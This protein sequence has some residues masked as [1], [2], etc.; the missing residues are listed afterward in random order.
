MHALTNQSD[1]FDGYYAAFSNYCFETLGWRYNS[2]VRFQKTEQFAHS[3]VIYDDI[4]EA[5]SIV[6]YPL[7]YNVDNLYDTLNIFD[8]NSGYLRNNIID[9]DFYEGFTSKQ[10]FI[11]E[12]VSTPI[13]TSPFD[14][15][16]VMIATKN[17][18]L[19][20]NNEIH[21]Y[22]PLSSSV[23]IMGISNIL[24]IDTIVNTYES[25]H[26]ETNLNIKVDA[27]TT[28]SIDETDPRI[29]HGVMYEL[30]SGD[31]YIKA[32]SE[33]KIPQ[34]N[35]FI[36]L[37][38]TV[39]VEYSNTPQ[40][41]VTCL[42]AGTDV[43]YKVCDRQ[44]YQEYKYDSSKP[45][46]ST[47]NFHKDPEHINDS[48]LIYPVVPS[49]NCN[50]KSNGT[51]YDF[52]E[53]LNV[54]ML[55]FDY[56]PIGNFSENVYTASDF[57]S[58][59]YVTNKIDNILYVNDEVT[60]YKDCILNK[61]VQNP[62]RKLLID[63]VNIKTASAY[64][65]ANIQSLEF[66][67]SGVK[68]SIKLNSKV[69]NSYIHLDEYTGFEVFVINDY[70]LTKKNELY[71]SIEEKFILLVNHQFY[72]EYAREAENNIKVIDQGN[73][74]PHAPY[75]AFAAPYSLDFASSGYMNKTF[76]GYKKDY[77]E[78][79]HKSLMSVIDEHNLWSSLFV[80]YDIPTD[81]YT[82]D[83]TNQ[84]VQTYIEPLTEYNDYVTI[85]NTDDYSLGLLSTDSIINPTS[86]VNFDL[87]SSRSESFVVTKA[88]GEYNHQ[89]QVLLQSIN[90]GIN[91]INEKYANGV[92]AFSMV[93]P[94]NGN[95]KDPV[96]KTSVEFINVA[97]LRKVTLNE[98]VMKTRLEKNTT[99]LVLDKLSK[100]L[101]GKELRVLLNPNDNN[102]VVDIS[103]DDKD[104]VMFPQ[105][106]F[107]PLQKYIEKLISLESDR[108]RL[109]RYCK[110]VDDNI[111]IYIIPEDSE[112]Q[113]IHNTNSYNP[114]MFDLFVPT[115]I[116]YN[117]GWFTP[118]TNEMVSY[119]TNDELGDLLNVDLLQGNTKIN[120]IRPIKN[121]TGNKVF[122][123]TTLTTLKEN[124]FMVPERSLLSTTWDNGY[125]RLYDSEDNYSNKPGFMTGI[126][127]KSF[128][129]SK[130]MVIHSPYLLLDTW[131]FYSNNDMYTVLTVD[132]SHNTRSKNTK[133]IQISI[134]LSAVIYAHFI[135]NKVFSE[136]WNRYEERQHTGMKNY[137][138]NIISTYYNL[139]SDIE[140]KLYAIDQVN[141][142][143]I[144]ILNEKPADASNYYVYENY[145]THVEYKNNIY[146]LTIVINET[147]GIN[148]SYCKI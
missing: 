100:T 146:T 125:Y 116:K 57:V 97:P 130:C 85:M 121:Y 71:I 41:N 65:N 19:L 119:D 75:A 25:V 60:T 129:G 10:Q 51:Y 34:G 89:A 69:V 4:Y 138:T 79:L 80:Q 11:F 135:N 107:K 36:L 81:V 6:K 30:V 143:N 113:C 46:L 23:A 88:D 52:N 148:I 128:F 95:L 33:T 134:N 144:N 22:K 7:V 12:T 91:T 72:I 29:Q 50:W 133:C 5:M 117:Y 31:F 15:N 26:M 139:N 86:S 17:E 111:D 13:I 54:D 48:E 142:S 90:D 21:L 109:E 61:K 115:H 20:D 141:K 2:V 74:V 122:E 18:S 8:I 105:R 39:Y 28:V 102:I 98:D 82:R 59:Q 9:P 40:T 99:Q 123:D 94:V 47:D 43:V 45:T 124:Y 78:S 145:S 55:K 93:Q 83:N 137:I 64:Y 14:V 120:N 76:V 101:G 140:V 127:D 108:E 16:Y 1:Y 49:V 104:D 96:D 73:Y 24:D 63:N 147:A 38:G 103:S 110:S 84:F 3:Y 58:N 87:I 112:V 35:K 44:Y 67:F 56:E 92:S 42:Y 131:E 68:F 77:E 53:I 37:P 62:I 106:Y 32:A 132:S 70:Q 118:N 126:D 114:L 27:Q 136:N 66:I